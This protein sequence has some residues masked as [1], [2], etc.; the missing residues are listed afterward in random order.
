MFFYSN[1]MPLSLTGK[2]VGLLKDLP[3][4]VSKNVSSQLI[5]DPKYLKLRPSKT[6]E[7]A[8]KTYKIQINIQCS[9]ILQNRYS[10]RYKSTR[11]IPIPSNSKA[12]N[13]KD[14]I[15]NMTADNI[16]HNIICLCLNKQ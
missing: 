16:K 7:N 5:G 14:Y 11:Q 2:M 8:I 3:I 10:S 6:W 15:R 9:T 12:K 13:Q 4:E 1:R